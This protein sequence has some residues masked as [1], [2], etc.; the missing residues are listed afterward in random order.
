MRVKVGNTVSD[1]DQ[2]PILLIFRDNEE[3]IDT[4]KNLTDMLKYSGPTPM[5]KMVIFPDTMAFKDAR[6][7]M[8]EFPP[9]EG[10]DDDS[11]DE[12]SKDQKSSQ[13]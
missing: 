5:R 4:I 3:L 11:V 12:S 9:K 2:E 7:F 1:S 10:K 6:K 8:D 13:V